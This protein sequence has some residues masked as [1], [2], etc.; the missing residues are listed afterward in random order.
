[1]V[2]VTLALLVLA[3]RDAWPCSV[4][5][6]P[7]ASVFGPTDRTE[8]GHRPWIRLWNVKPSVNVTLQLT[9]PCRQRRSC[10]DRVL[11]PIDR[12]GAFLR[13]RQPLAAGTRV[14]VQAGEQTLSTFIVTSSPAA[15]LPAWSGMTRPVLTRGREVMCAPAGPVVTTQVLPT[16]ADLSDAVLLVYTRKPDPKRPYA[17]L[18]AI[19]RLEIGELELRN[20]LGNVWLADKPQ[21]LWTAISDGDGNVGPIVEH[22]LAQ[23][24]DVLGPKDASEPRGSRPWIRVW[25]ARGLTLQTV[26]PACD[27]SA[28]CAPTM[29]A[30]LERGGDYVRPRN[31]LP[32]G[33]RVQLVAGK[34][35]LADF[36]VRTTPDP[37]LPALSLSL[38]PPASGSPIACPTPTLVV[39]D[40]S[41]VDTSTVV[42]LVYATKPDP[43]RPLAKLSAALRLDG[44]WLDFGAPGQCLFA[45]L[46]PALWT[47][48]ATDGGAIGPPV[49]HD[50][51]PKG[52][53]W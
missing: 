27:P 49:E 42:I 46:P 17:H 15:Q 4:S 6:D 41:Q 21:T 33:A 22:S 9:A 26:D 52:M 13:P 44:R 35:V 7:R 51:R 29:T 28:V 11:V 2:V 30:A 47:M 8:R 48:I 38:G 20:D 12:D 53:T 18:G 23:R 10:V 1:M 37:P 36:T 31:P 43:A 39:P 45:K 14:W 3:T 16:K 40:L 19:Y 5:L 24:V 34:S 32:A 50:L 25:G